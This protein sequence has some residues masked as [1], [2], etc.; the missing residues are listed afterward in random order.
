[1]TDLANRTSLPVGKLPSSLLGR[2]L[3]EYQSSDPS[4]L[5]GPGIGRDA[6]AIAIGGAVLVVKNDPITFASHSAAT[7]LVDVN[8]NDLACLG[9]VPRWLLV[10]ALLPEGVN[11]AE[12]ERQFAELFTACARRG[13]SLVG[14]H[15]EITAGVDRTILVGHLLGETTAD[16]LLRPGGAQPGDVLLLTKALA[17]EGTAL[18]ANERPGFLTQTVGE[19]T[20]KRARRLLDEPGISVLRDAEVLLA[21]GGVTALHDPTEGGL[22][23]AVRELAGAASRAA[24]IDRGAV[25]ILP[26]TSRLAAALGLDPLG[27]LASGSLLAAAEPAA[28]SG[29][30]EAGRREGIPV[31]EIGLVREADAGFTLRGDAG[32]TELPRF[33]TDEVSR[34]LTSGPGTTADKEERRAM[35]SETVNTR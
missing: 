28:V 33:N 3:A 5:V 8:A 16:R 25:P 21:A 34:W 19:E 24:E 27:M 20:V 26:E 11:A 12:I 10:T 13:I 31:T 17:L 1:M 4:V 23:M 35:P 15:T 29:L 30:L 18:L 2:L 32:V 9:A 6:A 14:G 22:A 7:Y